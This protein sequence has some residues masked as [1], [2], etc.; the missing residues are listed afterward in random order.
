MKGNLSN[1]PT[2]PSTNLTDKQRQLL[3]PEMEQKA[4]DACLEKAESEECSILNPEGF[5][6]KG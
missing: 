2:R 5:E 6:M 1:L 3:M 4:I